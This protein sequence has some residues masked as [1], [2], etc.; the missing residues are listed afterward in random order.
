MDVYTGTDTATHTHIADEVVF[1]GTVDR[2]CLDLKIPELLR[3]YIKI[4][5]PHARCV[6]W[7][8]CHRQIPL[9]IRPTQ[10]SKATVG[11][12][13]KGNKTVITQIR[14]HRCVSS[15]ATDRGGSRASKK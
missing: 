11:T 13:K 8:S 14:F 10:I 4:R 1:G 6:V 12:N 9:T 15:L 2:P 3:P 5:I 7:P